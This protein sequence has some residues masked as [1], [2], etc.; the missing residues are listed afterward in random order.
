LG[1][2]VLDDALLPRNI[3]GT[4]GE[5]LEGVLPEIVVTEEWKRSMKEMLPVPWKEKVAEYSRKY[6]LRRVSVNERRQSSFYS[7][8]AQPRFAPL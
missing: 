8:A 4:V 5:R 3:C 2:R 6:S 7:I 1:C